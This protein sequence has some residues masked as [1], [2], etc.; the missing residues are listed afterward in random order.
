MEHQLEPIELRKRRPPTLWQMVVAAMLCAM[1][2]VVTLIRIQ[3]QANGNYI[4]LGDSMVYLAASLLPTGYAVGAAAVGGALADLLAGAP[5]WILATAPIKAC[6]A[7]LFTSKG[8]SIINKRNVIAC[9]LAAPI[10]CGGY[11]LAECLIYG[12]WVV[13]LTMIPLNLLQVAASGVAYWAIA[14]LLERSGFLRRFWG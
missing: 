8:R 4:H 6:L 2:T 11:Y 12:N 13:P 9:F 7:L 1:V 14:A 3:V 10:T 5:V